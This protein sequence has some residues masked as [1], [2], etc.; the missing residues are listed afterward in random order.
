MALLG[1]ANAVKNLTQ[2]PRC[3][4]TLFYFALHVYESI[5][6][7]I[8]FSSQRLQTENTISQSEMSSARGW[9]R[10]GGRAEGHRGLC[11]SLLFVCAD[12][13]LF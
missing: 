10:L 13:N 5:D 2:H 6:L 7:Y 11:N 3:S 9:M 4:A 1:V 12:I 8:D